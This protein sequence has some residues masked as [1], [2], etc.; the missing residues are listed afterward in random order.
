MKKI[1]LIYFVVLLFSFGCEDW[2]DINDNPNSPVDVQANL[3]LPAAQVNSAFV[4]ANDLN[5]QTSALVQHYA[6]T[7]N[8]LL[9][10]DTYNFNGT[11]ADNPWTFGLY[12][13]ALLDYQRIV[14]I[15][16]T[17]EDNVMAGIAKISQAYL[18]AITTDLYDEVP[19]SDA[20][21]GTDVVAPGFDSQE[22]V[23]DGIFQLLNDGIANLNSPNPG[24]NPGTADLIYG[25][26]AASWVRLANGL[27]LKYWTQIRKQRSA[28]ATTEINNLIA[29]GGLMQ[30]N[31]D[32]YSLPFGTATGS[33]HP[34]FDFAF[35]RRAG[36]IAVSQRFIDSLNALS[37]PRIDFYFL[38]QGQ[39]NFVGYDNGGI[40]AVPA[41]GVRAL[42]GTFPVGP[43]GEAPQRM[44][45]YYSQQFYLAE[46]DLTLGITGDARDYYESALTAS[47]DHVGVGEADAAT[48]LADR[49]AAFD[50]AADDDARLAI[51]MRDK[52]VASFGN[53][54]EAYNDWRRTGFPQLAPA[55]TAL[56]PDGTI[57]RRLLYSSNELSSNPNLEN[58]AL[59]IDRVW[60]D[61]Q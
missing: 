48:Y 61:V 30:S 32:N 44:Y 59:L 16:E 11:E 58:Q 52:W 43:N 60:W 3:I 12:A 47:L 28:E 41:A 46:A 36:D 53:G 8:Q 55:T 51:V 33:Q 29:G 23:Y 39:G 6:G 45:T 2:L 9:S 34:M 40:A 57:P 49:L 1:N 35:N 50:A 10:F 54:V 26:D 25:G 13:G 22:S 5:R 20:L 14:E 42:L 24:V 27:K 4:T 37:D 38:D 17:N 19:F 31:G 56:T 15:S 7:N 18:F 21:K